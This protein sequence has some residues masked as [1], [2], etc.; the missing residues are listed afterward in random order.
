MIA[1]IKVHLEQQKIMAIVKHSF[2]LKYV[3]L[4]AHLIANVGKNSCNLQSG[5]L[6]HHVNGKSTINPEHLRKV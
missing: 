3:I 5:L 4:G 6:N 1:Q 2:L